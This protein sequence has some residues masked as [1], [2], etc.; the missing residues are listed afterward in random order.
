MSVMRDQRHSSAVKSTGCFS[1]DLGSSPSTHMAV[2]NRLAST[3]TKHAHSAQETPIHT[4]KGRKQKAH[5]RPCMLIT[6]S[7]QSCSGR[8][9]DA[10]IHPSPYQKRLQTRSPAL[11]VEAVEAGMAWGMELYTS[12]PTGSDTILMIQLRRCPGADYEA[13]EPKLPR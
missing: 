9:S 7:A 2:H 1:G 11:T 3:D 5:A 8:S 12:H 6:K 4:H 10:F 13:I